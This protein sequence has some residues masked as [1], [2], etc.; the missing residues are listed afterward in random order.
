M[1]Q[2]SQI[3]C[4][5]IPR[6]FSSFLQFTDQELL[7]W[8]HAVQ[9][10]RFLNPVFCQNNTLVSHWSL[11]SPDSMAPSLI[12]I[13]CRYGSV[14][15]HHSFSEWQV[16]PVSLSFQKHA[17]VRFYCRSSPETSS[18][19]TQRDE[20]ARPTECCHLTVSRRRFS[21]VNH[22]DQQTPLIT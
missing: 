14:L 17:Q 20:S 2:F 7:L 18:S 6:K 10:F 16:T 4:H 19:S 22:I 1:K 21:N 3:L 15:V 5:V 11:A 12:R 13:F 9:R 8:C